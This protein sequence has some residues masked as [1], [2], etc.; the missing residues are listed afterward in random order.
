MSGGGAGGG[1]AGQPPVGTCTSRRPRRALPSPPADTGV[2]PPVSSGDAILDAGTTKYGAECGVPY[3]TL[4]RQGDATHAKPWHSMDLGPIH[5]VFLSSELDMSAGS[6][7]QKWVIADL[8]AVDRVK[9]PFVVVQ[10]HRL[11]YSVRGRSA[12]AARRL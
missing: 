9:T 10:W 11:M 3:E 8:A 2:S 5:F 4:F 7:Q 6:P 1:G 12:A